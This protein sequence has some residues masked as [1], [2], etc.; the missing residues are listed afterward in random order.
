MKKLISLG[1]FV[2][3]YNKLTNSDLTKIFS[4][5]IPSSS[6]KRVTKSWDSATG[7]VNTNWWSVPYIQK[8][9][10]KLITENDDTEYPEYLVNKYFLGRKNL[11]LLSPGCGTGGKELKFSKFIF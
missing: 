11:V 3:V 6:K 9:W 4:R 8:R 1:D 7:S 5:L 2:D 10:N